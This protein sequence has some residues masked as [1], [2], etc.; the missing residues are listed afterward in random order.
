VYSISNAGIEDIPLI[1]ELCF[2]VWPQTYAPL[3]SEEQVSYML[4]LMYSEA[5]LREQINAGAQFIILRTELDEP[6]GFASYQAIDP[7]VFKLHKLYVLPS[8]QGKGSGRFIIDTI[9]SRIKEKG[10]HSLRLQVHKKNNARLFYD[11]LGFVIIED[12]R[13][14]IGRGYIMDDYIMEKKITV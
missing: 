13:L 9:I 5:S 12:L 4:E 1:R 14:D 3:L 7:G 11:K 6:V 8:E 2:K 10:A